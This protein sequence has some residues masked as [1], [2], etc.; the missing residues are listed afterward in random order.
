MH[1]IFL[2]RPLLTVILCLSI[3][4]LIACGGD[5]QVE[6]NDAVASEGL[7]S[8]PDPIIIQTDWFPESEYGATYELFGDG[9]Y[10]IM[11]IAQ[12]PELFTMEKLI[13]ALDLRSE[14]VALLLVLLQ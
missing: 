5:S 12:L 9:I 3:S 8:C 1:K 11:R 10:L 4:G 6:E 13:L 2:P 7:D 14:L